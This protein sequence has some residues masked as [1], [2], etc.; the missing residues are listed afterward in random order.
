MSKMGGVS[1]TLTY[2]IDRIVKRLSDILEKVEELIDVEKNP[3]L[4]E[5]NKAINEDT[6][7][8]MRTIELFENMINT[9]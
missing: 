4:K 1:K 3:V 7:D 5:V 6:F 8:V 2:A 9:V